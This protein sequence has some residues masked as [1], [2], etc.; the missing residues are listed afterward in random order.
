MRSRSLWSLTLLC[1]LAVPVAAIAQG[2][3]PA[4]PVRILV[5]LSAGSQVDIL[6]RVAAQKLSESLG[7]PFL[8]ENRTGAGG[9]IASAAVATA[10]ADGYTLLMVANGHAIN[11]W[12]YEKLPYDTLKD[13]AGVSLVATVPSVL[14]VPPA[15]GAKNVL[16]LVE[17]AR[18]RPGQLNYA[19]PGTGSA[20]HLAAE[21]FK[22]MAKVRAEHVPYKGTPEALTDTLTGRAQFFFAPLGAALPAIKDGKLVALAVTTRERSAALPAVPTLDEAGVPGYRFE[23]W[24]ALFAP[25]GTPRAVLDL[26]AAEIAK[27]LTKPDVKEKLAAQGAASAPLPTA[28]L[29]AFVREEVEKLGQL[30]KASGA[31]AM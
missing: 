20:G 16:E 8:V 13:F 17:M 15:L 28:Q 29:D 25:R 27:A 30:V 1:C 4:R 22:L 19:S 9:S 23:F 10:A 3:Y 24:Y 12:I 14:V 7:Q 5:T 26:L 6:A 18:A 31:K 21:Q 11:P 2:E